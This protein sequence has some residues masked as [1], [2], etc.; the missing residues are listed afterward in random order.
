MSSC[1]CNSGEVTLVWA[2]HTLLNFRFQE[3]SLEGAGSNQQKHMKHAEALQVH[4]RQTQ[5]LSEVVQQHNQRVN[6]TAWR[7]L[8]L[9]QQQPSES[10]KTPA[11]DNQPEGDITLA[12]GGLQEKENTARVTEPLSDLQEYVIDNLELIADLVKQVSVLD[13]RTTQLYSKQR[14]YSG[15]SSED[16]V[17]T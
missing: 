4:A 2:A 7:G 11:G 16:E 10:S 6:T 3:E 5:Q 9:H 8:S 14:E 15:D 13:R 12:S 17:E 1:S